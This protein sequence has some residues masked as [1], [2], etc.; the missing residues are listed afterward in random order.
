MWWYGIEGGFA[1]PITRVA[2]VR[3]TTAPLPGKRESTILIRVARTPQGLLLKAFQAVGGSVGSGLM[4]IGSAA[5]VCVQRAVAIA[6][7]ERYAGSR[8]P[9]P[10]QPVANAKGTAVRHWR[11]WRKEVKRPITLETYVGYPLESVGLKSA[12][13]PFATPLV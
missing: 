6:G 5:V 4:P 8:V 11:H 7:S 3:C 10:R 2:V 1:C 12:V 9:Q 13:G